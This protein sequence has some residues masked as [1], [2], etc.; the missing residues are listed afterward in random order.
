MQGEKENIARKAA[1][2]GRKSATFCYVGAKAPPPLTSF[3]SL[4]VACLLKVNTWSVS[5]ERRRHRAQTD[6]N[7][8]KSRELL[9][10][11]N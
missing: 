11:R 9:L 4:K 6:A 5:C 1:R 8:K 7:R 3:P 2:I 10:Y